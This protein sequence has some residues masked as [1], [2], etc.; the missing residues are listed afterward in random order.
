MFSYQLQ[1]KYHEFRDHEA[2]LNSF[3][4]QEKL[5]QNNDHVNHKYHKTD[6]FPPH[7]TRFTKLPRAHVTII[8]TLAHSNA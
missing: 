4:F 5:L 2:S 8:V 3:L 7:F 1:I 6:S